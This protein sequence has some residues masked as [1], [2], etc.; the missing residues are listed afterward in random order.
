M[1]VNSVQF[2]LPQNLQNLRPGLT[3]TE[4]S[5]VFVR[6]L[7]D[8]TDGKALVSLMGNKVTVQSREPMAQ[9][10]SFPAAVHLRGDGTI[11]LTRLSF[12]APTPA[13]T[14]G[15]MH[16][17]DALYALLASEGFVPDALSARIFQF[18]YQTGVKIDSSIMQKARAIASR[19]PGKE[20]KAA[21]IASLLMEEGIEPTDEAIQALMNLCGGQYGSQEGKNQQDQQNRGQNS[22]EE[23]NGFLE[24]IYGRTIPDKSG[25]LT[26]LNQVS[27][28]R[29]HWIFLPF[30][31]DLPL[32]QTNGIAAETEGKTNAGGMIRLLIDTEEHSLKKVQ[33]NCKT[34][35][36]NYYFVLYYN[37]IS[38]EKEVRFFTL[39]PLL[40]SAVQAEEM[41]LGGFFNSGMSDKP[42]TVTY[43]DSAYF[44]GLCVTNE[45]PAL[46]QERI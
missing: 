5:Q 17:M 36:T 10:E 42:V 6:V 27:R 24:K 18:M 37:S 32:D 12:P 4:G 9:G 2:I 46:I 40:P 35:M 22:G 34:V 11:E 30:E 33:I 38:N 19:F 44:D 23:N 26:Y 29:H 3:L 20:E 41:R 28:G 45:T 8:S 15:Q 1:A 43:S 25:L 31:W 7:A 14:T 21:E 16:G 39:P 13:E